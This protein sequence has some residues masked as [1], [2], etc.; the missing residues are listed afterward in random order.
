MVRKELIIRSLTGVAFVAILVGAIM[1]G[2]VSFAVLF[3]V[4]T[5]MTVWEFCTIVN[6]H[7]DSQVN[8]LIAT[9][10]SVYFFGCVM[11]FNANL[12]GSE[13]FIPYVITL[14]YLFISELYFKENNTLHNWSFTMMSQLYVALPFALLNTLSFLPLPV[15]GGDLGAVYFPVFTLSIFIFIWSSDTGAYCFGSWLGRHKLFPRISPNKSWEGVIGG[16]FVAVVASQAIATFFPAFSSTS[17]LLNRLGW[18]GLA[19]VVVIFG[20]WGDLVESLLKRRLGIKDS[21]HILPGHGG[22]LDRFDSA[23]IAIPAAVAYIWILNS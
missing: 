9:I 7:A 19:F 15:G 14:V 13:I 22:M 11:A 16:A 5:G 12:K 4:I 17:H 8:R 20:T 6:N 2:P 21:G 1:F 23:L 10:A 3:A 18:T